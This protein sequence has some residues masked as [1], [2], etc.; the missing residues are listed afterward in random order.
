MS[1]KG[2]NIY[3]RKDGRWEGRYKKGVAANGR[4]IR[5]ET[6]QSRAGTVRTAAQRKLPGVCRTVLR[7]HGSCTGRP[8]MC[9]P[10]GAVQHH[11]PR[12]P[13]LPP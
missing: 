7:L 8:R 6:D 10:V 13:F 5:S 11:H 4:I 9:F 2:E 1:R 12:R 3:K